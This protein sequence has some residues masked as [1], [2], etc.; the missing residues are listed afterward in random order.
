MLIGRLIT[1]E[2]FRGEFLDNPEGTL[3]ELL[4]RGLELTSTEVTALVSTDP[5][6]WV[7]AAELLDPR[8]QKAAF[9]HELIS[10][11]KGTHHV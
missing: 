2:Q 3:A 1:D 7:R 8:L 10:T 9:S 11:K 6:V 5:T 4:G